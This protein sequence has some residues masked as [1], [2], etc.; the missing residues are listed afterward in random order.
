MNCSHRFTSYMTQHESG[1]PRGY[2]L[3][4]RTSA[5]LCKTSFGDS[6]PYILHNPNAAIPSTRFPFASVFDARNRQVAAISYSGSHVNVQ[7]FAFDGD[8]AFLL[9]V[10][11]HHASHIKTMEEGRGCETWPQAPAR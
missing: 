2:E 3:V 6:M 5:F 11:L 9:W 10:I 7:F 4:R 8:F 1:S